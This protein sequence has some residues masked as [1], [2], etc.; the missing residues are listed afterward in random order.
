MFE[1]FPVNR[2]DGREGAKEFRRAKENSRADPDALLTCSDM[3]KAYM[4]YR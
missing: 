4:L 3:L 2:E 1:D